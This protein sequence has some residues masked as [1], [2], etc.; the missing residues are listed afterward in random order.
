MLRRRA[1]HSLRC[2]RRRHRGCLGIYRN[3]GCSILRHGW[4]RGRW[5][6][7]RCSRAHS[8]FD[9]V[10]AACA[11]GA[12]RC[13]SDVRCVSGVHAISVDGCVCKRSRRALG[14]LR[15][16]RFDASQRRGRALFRLLSA[17][18]LRGW[19]RRVGRR[20]RPRPADVRHQRRKHVRARPVIALCHGRRQ[21]GHR[22]PDE[23]VQLRA[24]M[25]GDLW[26]C[27]HGHG[28]LA[29][30]FEQQLSN[31]ASAP[32]APL[33]HRVLRRTAA[34]QLLQQRRRVL[35]G[36]VVRLHAR[37][38]RALWHARRLPWWRRRLCLQL[39]RR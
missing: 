10:C 36:A 8:P 38:G 34:Q 28:A 13:V 5:L 14:P 39:C 27:A 20:R 22:S 2:S 6:V 33:V 26:A 11:V 4:Q 3:V 35:S 25:R 15:C 18:L 30:R 7:R 1:R 23:R 17:P 24:R 9:R 32:H 37:S 16:R 31:E 21:C 12:I 29:A 19:A